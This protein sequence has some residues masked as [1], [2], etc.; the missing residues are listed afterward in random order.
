MTWVETDRD[1][2]K[3]AQAVGAERTEH[4][5]ARHAEEFV[6]LVAMIEESGPDSI[7]GEI[8]ICQVCRALDN[9]AAAIGEAKE[10]AQYLARRGP[11][12]TRV[13]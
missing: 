5:G 1:L 13:K 6:R 10:A 12:D 4:V 9:C 11:T 2:D 8:E 7:V 3:L